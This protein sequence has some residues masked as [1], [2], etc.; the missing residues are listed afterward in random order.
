MLRISAAAYAWKAVL[1]K[2][3][4]HHGFAAFCAGFNRRK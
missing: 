3:L 1:S 4:S 2:N